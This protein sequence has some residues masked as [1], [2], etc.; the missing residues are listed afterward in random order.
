[1]STTQSPLDS[2]M[3]TNDIYNTQF[4]SIIDSWTQPRCPGSYDG[5]SEFYDMA[6]RKCLSIPRAAFTPEKM[7][8]SASSCGGGKPFKVGLEINGN[9]R[10]FDTNTA[11]ASSWYPNQA[12]DTQQVPVRPDDLMNGR[13]VCG[14]T[15]WRR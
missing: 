6:S 5:K 1:M 9:V 14:T 7:A 15:Q 3:A 12:L 2:V 13:G 11:P 8:A 10:C 4:T